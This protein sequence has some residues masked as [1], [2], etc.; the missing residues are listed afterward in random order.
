M[1]GA[2][3]MALTKLKWAVGG[4]APG[5][6]C[7]ALGLFRAVGQQCHR[8]GGHGGEDQPWDG[9][10]EAEVE[11]EPVTELP[12]RTIRPETEDRAPV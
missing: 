9:G 7:G 2:L 4:S 5:Q 11:Q 6:P 1:Y 3:Q 8:Q 10:R 12:R